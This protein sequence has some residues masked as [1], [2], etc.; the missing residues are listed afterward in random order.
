MAGQLL[1]RLGLLRSRRVAWAGVVGRR[2]ADLLRCCLVR[3]LRPTRLEATLTGG[4]RR[5]LLPG[6]PASS[7]GYLAGPLRSAS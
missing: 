1:R 2:T 6:A 5:G 4:K 7:P 3:A